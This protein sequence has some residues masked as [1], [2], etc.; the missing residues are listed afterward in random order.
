LRDRSAEL[1]GV[2]NGIDDEVWNP[3]V[4]PLIPA[5]FSAKDLDGKA[6]C[7]AELQ[8]SA[9]L[10][11]RPGV[12]LI[13]IVTR[14]AYQKGIDVVL[15]AMPGL[16]ELGIQMVVLA[17]GD[18]NLEGR[19]EGWARARPEQLAVHVGYSEPL[20]HWIEAGS[21]FFLMPSRYEPCGLNQM[22]S[23]R[24]GTHPNVRSVGGLEDTVVNCDPA[25][26]RG[27]GF[28]FHDLHPTSLWN[29]VR[30]AVQIYWSR[31]ELIRQM[32]Q[33]AMG[34]GLGWDQAARIYETLYGLAVEKRT[35]RSVGE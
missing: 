29:T 6:F 13:G 22:Y 1:F 24:Y 31:P 23:L 11:Q 10:P 33:W 14:L 16:L 9:G 2:L 19:L 21:D 27:T 25:T 12:P 26:S 8:R 15:D 20:A 34:Q 17:S 7:K 5:R 35:G 18:S 4:D 3:E 28:K 30:W 32:R